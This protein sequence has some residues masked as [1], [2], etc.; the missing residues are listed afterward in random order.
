MK[1]DDASGSVFIYKAFDLALTGEKC[2]V[3]AH[4]QG[5]SA[6]DRGLT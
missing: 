2:G 5:H 3:Q 4:C 1:T 6:S